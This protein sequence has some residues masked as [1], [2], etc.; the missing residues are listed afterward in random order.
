MNR[1]KSIFEILENTWPDAKC[2]LEHNNHFQLL[3]AVL[4]SAQTTDKS[5]NKALAPILAKNPLFSPI[6]LVEMGESDFLKAIKSIG[7]APT[8]A[9]NSL[10]TALL[11]IEKYQGHVPLNREDLES[12][13][14][15]GRKT[16]NVVLNVL[17][18]LPTM[19]VDTHVERV[20]IRLGL[21]LPT[22]N[23]LK[24]EQELL[25]KVPKKFA[26]QAHHLLIFH[27]RYHCTARNPKCGTCPVEQLCKKIGLNEE[28]NNE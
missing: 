10:K 2:E 26:H 14:G 22:K 1:I 4:L 13:P 25:R 8:K 3:L 27:G 5:V 20:S 15:V 18:K 21:V 7:L 11:L 17:C 23:R 24:I 6:D 9:R 12:L 28:K 19:P 16:A